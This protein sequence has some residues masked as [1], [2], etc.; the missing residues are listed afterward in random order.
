MHNATAETIFRQTDPLPDTTEP[1]PDNSGF[2]SPADF[3]PG[4]VEKAERLVRGGHE[5]ASDP[6]P[7]PL[8]NAFLP[9]P[10]VAAGLELRPVVASDWAI[11][12]RLDSPI[13][14]ELARASVA[15]KNPE[16]AGPT[17]TFEEEDIWELLFLWTNPPPVVRAAL[18]K[19]RPQFREHVLATLADKLPGGVIGQG[20][21]LIDALFGN[22]L[23]SLST[24][25]GHEPRAESNA[26]FRLAPP[27]TASAGGSV[28]S[29]R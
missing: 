8:L 5:A 21:Q 15:A 4:Y 14:K 2:V 19:G 10:L 18:A 27:A 1:A 11:L 7:G 6:L 17:T 24:Q 12:K 20:Q 25:I 16:L 29:G 13:L 9:E 28:T 26:D 22:L 23:R 3:P